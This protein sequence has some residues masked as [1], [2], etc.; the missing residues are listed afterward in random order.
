MDKDLE[1]VGRRGQGCMGGTAKCHTLAWCAWIPRGRQTQLA[2][3][4]PSCTMQMTHCAGGG[5]HSA[6]ST[7]VQ[8]DL[9]KCAGRR[10]QKLEVHFNCMFEAWMAFSRGPRNCTGPWD[11]STVLYPLLHRPSY[12]DRSNRNP[13]IH[14]Q[15]HQTNNQLCSMWI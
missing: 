13:V 12:R 14:K 15:E 5:S 11:P 10:S 7:Q 6:R 1:K 3:R 9:A 8:C 2:T 4:L